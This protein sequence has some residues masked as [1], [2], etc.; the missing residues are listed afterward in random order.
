MEFEEN[1]PTS[2]ADRR[3]AEA[4]KLT[5]QPIHA[6]VIPENPSDSEVASRHLN[7]PAIA[8]IATDIEESTS[9][10]Q[11]TES[12]LQPYSRDSSHSRKLIISLT[13]GITLFMSLIVIALLK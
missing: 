5:L 1:K 3:M 10:V 6:D 4:K 11:P 2:D 8:N 7:E 9:I 13:A 12:L